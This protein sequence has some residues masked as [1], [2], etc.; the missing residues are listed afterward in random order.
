VSY[1]W[2]GCT[3][4]GTDCSGFVQS[5]FARLGV[6]LPRTAEQQSKIGQRVSLTELH[7]GDLIFFQNVSGHVYHVAI[8]VAPQEMAFV[9]ASCSRGVARDILT[10]PYYQ[11]RVGMAKRLL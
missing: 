6:T 3:T 4:S 10:K 2:G 7:K 8:M 11:E 9:H 1:V 5:V